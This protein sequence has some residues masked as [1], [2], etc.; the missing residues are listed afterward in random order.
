MNPA[1]SP[2]YITASNMIM[3][4]MMISNEAIISFITRATEFVRNFFS[5]ATTAK[6]LMWK[7][8]I[9]NY[10][11]INYDN[12]FVIGIMSCFVGVML[13][14]KY[15]FTCVYYN[16]LTQKVKELEKELHYIKKADRMRDN[17]IE[18]IMQSQTQGFKQLQSDFD[19]KITSQE[20]QLKK[21][22]KELKMY[23]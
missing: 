16:P 22:D 21:I 11:N 10:A 9:K 13:Y 8:A 20:K 7:E 3:P 18:L 1:I 2:V 14:E 4:I 12:L 23:Q 6:A 15:L 5:I 19:K 17:D